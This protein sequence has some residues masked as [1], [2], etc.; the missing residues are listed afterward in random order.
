MSLGTILI[1]IV[2]LM[3]HVLYKNRPEEAQWKLFGLTLF[4]STFVNCGYAFKI[5]S[6]TI[7]YNIWCEILYIVGAVLLVNKDSFF[8]KKKVLISDCIV[9][10]A[11]IAGL[12]VLQYNKERPLIIPWTTR[13]DDV[14][15]QL[16]KAEYPQLG[17]GNYLNLF[18][19][20]FFSC[21]WH[22]PF[23]FSMTRNM[24][25]V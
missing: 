5:G 13:M 10:I 21:S 7:T 1:F 12:Y 16:A 19:G 24:L 6:I 9:I 14:Y 18:Y 20:A 25:S 23:D 15:Y 3:T 11:I 17:Y 2:F 4:I 8:V 22:Y